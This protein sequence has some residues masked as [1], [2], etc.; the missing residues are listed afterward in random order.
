VIKVAN[1][2]TSQ[3]L[4]Q[5]VKGLQSVCPPIYGLD[6]VLVQGNGLVTVFDN[7]VKL[8]RLHVHVTFIQGQQITGGLNSGTLTSAAVTVKYG[9]LCRRNVDS[10]SVELRSLFEILLL[11][12]FVALFL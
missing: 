8:R 11:I 2:S 3:R 5:S 9:F 1:R 7:E 6:I 12:I 10:T 4:L